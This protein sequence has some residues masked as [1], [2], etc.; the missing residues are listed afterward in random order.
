MPKHLPRFRINMPSQ[1]PER[2]VQQEIMCRYFIKEQ[3][4][5]R[6]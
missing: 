1:E 3:S 2:F 5:G 4:R 6:G